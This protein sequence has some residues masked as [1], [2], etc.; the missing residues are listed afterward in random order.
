MK[1]EDLLIE[2]TVGF[3]YER[4]PNLW[5]DFIS[6]WLQFVYDYK[7]HQLDYNLIYYWNEK[8]SMIF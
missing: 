3:Q 1:P 5:F 2:F 6:W 7:I 4:N 8:I